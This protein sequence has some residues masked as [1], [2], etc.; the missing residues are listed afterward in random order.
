MEDLTNLIGAW[1]N[2][3][4]WIVCSW[5]E[6]WKQVLNF[7]WSENEE[8]A[9]KLR[10][11]ALIKRASLFI[12][13]CKVKYIHLT[14]LNCDSIATYSFKTPF[15]QNNHRRTQARIPS[16]ALLTLP[17]LWNLIL[18]MLTSTITEARLGKCIENFR[19]ACPI[20]STKFLPQVH[21]LI[22]QINAAIVDFNKAVDLQPNFPVA[23][24][25]KLYTDYRLKQ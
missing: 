16:W 23:Y 9:V 12:Q 7:S 1:F 5:K 25:Q 20:H 14:T 17:P 13:Q 3:L 6:E 24:V 15:N 22:D 21:L 8:A 10:V 4:R 2:F 11:N 19:I 18:T